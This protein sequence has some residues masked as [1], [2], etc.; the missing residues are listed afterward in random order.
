[1]TIH[2]PRPIAIALLVLVGGGAVAMIVPQI[3]DI[4]KYIRQEGM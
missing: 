3:P 2:V 1:M 4:W